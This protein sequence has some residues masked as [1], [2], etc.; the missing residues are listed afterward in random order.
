[1]N[2]FKSFIDWFN[3]DDVIELGLYDISPINAWLEENNTELMEKVKNMFIYD[4][5]ICICSHYNI[6]CPK[7]TDFIAGTAH[8]VIDDLN[9]AIGKS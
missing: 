9:K 1:M 8:R 7:E 5:L 4:G 3:K 6:K 2:I